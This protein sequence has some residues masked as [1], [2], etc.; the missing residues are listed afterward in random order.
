MK[1]SNPIPVSEM[2]VNHLNIFDL[3]FGHWNVKNTD[4]YE[5]QD[6]SFKEI[7]IISKSETIWRNNRW[8]LNELRK[9]FSKIDEGDRDLDPNNF[10][11]GK[12]IAYIEHIKNW[13]LLNNVFA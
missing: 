1:N 8:S 2:V 3:F 4:I 12:E 7:I 6:A 13:Y 10:W 5:E 9:I 11:G